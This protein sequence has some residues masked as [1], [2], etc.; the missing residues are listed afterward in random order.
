[1]KKV[2]MVTGLFAVLVMQVACKGVKNVSGTLTKSGSTHRDYLH[3]KSADDA[4][5]T[6]GR[7]AVRGDSAGQSGNRSMAGPSR[8]SSPEA[9][10]PPQQDGAYRKDYGRSASSVEKAVSDMPVNPSSDFNDRILKQY[11]E[12][13]RLADLV[14]YELGIVERRMELFLAKYKSASPLEREKI[15]AD[16]DQLSADQLK[17]YRA[18]VKIYKEGKTDWALT[19]KEVESVLLV[20]RGLGEK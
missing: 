16:L 14:L 10:R 15:A 11:S 12:M 9:A 5:N 8:I 3:D 2:L 7:T 18:H 4:T 13:D 20:V 19:K 1:M 17:L 6:P